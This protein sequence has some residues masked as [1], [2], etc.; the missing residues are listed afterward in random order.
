MELGSLLE[1]QETMAKQMAEVLLK[2]EEEA[3]C[4]KKGKSDMNTEK[5]EFVKSS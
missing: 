3:L 4:T 2:D 1:N 5:N